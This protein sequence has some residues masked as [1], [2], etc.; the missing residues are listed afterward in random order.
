MRKRQER[1]M[2]DGTRSFFKHTY[3]SHEIATRLQ[4][5]VVKK[6]NGR[7]TADE[8]AIHFQRGQE[9][10]WRRAGETRVPWS[11]TRSPSRSN[12]FP[13]LEN[14]VSRS[15]GSSRGS[16]RGRSREGRE[17]AREGGR[18]KKTNHPFVRR[19]SPHVTLERNDST[20]WQERT[21]VPLF[22][23]IEEKTT[24]GELQS[25]S[26]SPRGR[27]GGGGG[28]TSL[29]PGYITHRVQCDV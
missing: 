4:G 10:G 12:P 3:L 1:R 26:V 17:I 7:P 16:S 18:K 13:N 24:K 19:D 15:S 9:E 6:V 11:E 8:R 29:F 23:G 20:T 25:V 14:E 21:P 27:R 5:L 22:R 28:K 2:N